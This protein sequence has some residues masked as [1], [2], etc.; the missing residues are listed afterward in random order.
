MTRI[1]PFITRHPVLTYFALVFAVTDPATAVSTVDETAT[2]YTLWGTSLPGALE[3]HLRRAEHVA[4]RVQAQT[5]AVM[6]DGVIRIA[7]HVEDPRL[8]LE[9]EDLSGQR[10][11]KRLCGFRC[12][13][14]VPPK[15]PPI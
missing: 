9:L 14:S 15:V 5:H 3:P 8:G 1:K 7:G 6:D 10:S 12:R 11:R 2:A 13:R 4:R